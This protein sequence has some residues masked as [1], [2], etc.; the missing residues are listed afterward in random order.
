MEDGLSKVES[1]EFQPNPTHPT[2]VDT[3]AAN[4]NDFADTFLKKN[5]EESKLDRIWRLHTFV[6]SEGILLGFL[7]R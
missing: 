4:F 7:G 2:K 1:G 6:S 5:F 3:H